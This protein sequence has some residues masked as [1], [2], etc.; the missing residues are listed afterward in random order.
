MS[1]VLTSQGYAGAKTTARDTNSLKIGLKFHL[2]KTKIMKMHSSVTTPITIKGKAVEEFKEFTYLGSKMTSD[3]DCSTDV[4]SRL[5]KAQ[6]TFVKLKPVM[7]SY[8]Y[9]IKTKLRIFQSNVL[10][11]LL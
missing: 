11:V 1:L 3:D 4:R 7:N 6:H 9:K 10:C 8:K 5:A 2:D